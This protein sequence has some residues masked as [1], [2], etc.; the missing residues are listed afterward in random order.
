TYLEADYTSE[1]WTALMTAK[2]DG[3]IAID[4]A[5]DPAGV[6]T[7]KDLA[8]AAMDAVP[9]IT[10]TLVIT[11]ISRTSGGDVTLVFSTIPNALLTLQ[12]STDLV[13]WTTIATVNPSTEVWTFVHVAAVQTGT[14][15]FY[16]AFINQ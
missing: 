8:L 6:T 12:T 11:V 7:A 9:T 15:R 1:N 3:D 5:A 2:T 4:A 13:A 10:E 14:Q 16:H